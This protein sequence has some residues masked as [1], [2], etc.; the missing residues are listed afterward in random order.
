[1]VKMFMQKSILL[2]EDYKFPFL[3]YIGV[4]FKDDEITSLKLYMHGFK[5]HDVSTVKPLF[6]RIELIAEQYAKFMETNYSLNDSE[7]LDHHPLSNMGSLFKFKITP[8]GNV[9]HTFFLRLPDYDQ[10]G[11]QE[12]NLPEIE[13]KVV[14]DYFCCETT[15]DGVLYKRYYPIEKSKNIKFVLN[16]FGFQNVNPNDIGI[17]E[18]LEYES[19]KKVAM[20]FKGSRIHEYIPTPVQKAV[21]FF[22]ENYGLS[23]MGLGRCNRSGTESLYLMEIT[24][25]RYFKDSFTFQQLL[26]DLANSIDGSDERA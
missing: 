22:K 14:D 12:L 10:G 3:S 21:D 9:S 13:D 1:M 4:D 25:R 23:P 2:F 8:D 15:N 16:E 7:Y 26:Y 18:Y 6:P 20:S 17:L 11:M 19:R 24:K 5:K